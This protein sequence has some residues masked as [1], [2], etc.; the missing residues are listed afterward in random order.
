MA[1]LP[2]NPT[3]AQFQEYVWAIE[4]E[5][6]FIDQTLLEKCLLLGEEIGELFKSIRKQT[7]MATDQS[8]R[9]SPVAEELADTFI[10]LLSVANHAGVDLETA[11]RKKEE[12]NEQ[13]VWSQ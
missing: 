8:T 10:M 11:F 4:K 3:L 13:R 7:G 5:R 12:S 2:S 6:G 1:D 9:V